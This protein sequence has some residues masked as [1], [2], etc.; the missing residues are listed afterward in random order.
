MTPEEKWNQLVRAFETSHNGNCDIPKL[1]TT[2]YGQKM[3]EAAMLRFAFEEAPCGPD[4][5]EYYRALGIRKDLFDNGNFYERYS[6]FSP[7]RAES[8]RKYPLVFWNHGG[9]NP[10]ET[11]EF[12][13]HIAQ[14]AQLEQIIV[15][16]LQ[17]TNA[18]CIDMA[19]DRLSELY[20][21][22]LERIYVMGYSQGGQAAHAALV[23][24][25]ERLAGVCAAGCDAFPLWDNLD[26]RFTVEELDHLRDVFVPVLQAAGQFEFLNLLPHNHWEN[27]YLW[28]NGVGVN[29]WINPRFD[30][31][32]DPTNPPGKRADKPKPPTHTDPDRWKLWKLNLRLWTQGCVAVNPN[33][34]L[35]YADEA[36]DSLHHILGFYGDREETR[37]LLGV[38]HFIS[39]TY[40]P[41][42]MLGYRYIGVENSPHWPPLLLGELAWEF[43]RNF[44]RDSVTGRIVQDTYF[45]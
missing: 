33:C 45:A 15:C 28:K 18:N 22:D 8:G 41:D 10:I 5:I 38:K 29:P 7:Q 13:I 44:R 4:C 40:R 11:D 9:G 2:E 32:N 42:G 19:I 43:F 26:I 30:L 37:E 35:S 20:P 6:V 1:L 14:M 16:M 21:I 12:S 36:P 17:T 27:I 34:C 24:I 25:P 23:R 31:A 39:D 3:K